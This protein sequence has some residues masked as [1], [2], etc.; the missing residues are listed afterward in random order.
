[1]LVIAKK[2]S[3][4]LQNRSVVF[5]TIW[6]SLSFFLFLIVLGIEFIKQR[7][8]LIPSKSTGTVTKKS[9]YRDP[10]I[11]IPFILIPT[12]CLSLFT[13][14]IPIVFSILCSMT[15]QLSI[16]SLSTLETRPEFLVILGYISIANTIFLRRCW[17]K[18]RRGPCSSTIYR[19]ILATV[20]RSLPMILTSTL[21][22][23]FIPLISILLLSQTLQSI[24]L[25]VSTLISN[26]CVQS[27]VLSV[28]LIRNT[29]NWCFPS[30]GTNFPLRQCQ[31]FIEEKL[32][33]IA[34]FIIKL[35][36]DL[37]SSRLKI[38]IFI[39]YMMAILS[40][41][42]VLFLR[43]YTHV[44]S[45][46]RHNK[47]QI[48]LEFHSYYP[49]ILSICLF[50]IP[51]A[52]LISINRLQ[53]HTIVTM[54]G[55]SFSMIVLDV[56]R[57]LLLYDRPLK[58]VEYILATVIPIDGCIRFSL[59][60]RLS[61]KKIHAAKV[62]DATDI[63]FSQ[64]T[65]SSI[66]SISSLM[67]IF[68]Y[69][70]SVKFIPILATVIASNWLNTVV[71]YPVATTLIGAFEFGKRRRNSQLSETRSFHTDRFSSHFLLENNADY[72]KKYNSTNYYGNAKQKRSYNVVITDSRRASMPVSVHK[73]S[74]T[75]PNDPILKKR[76][77]ANGAHFSM[78]TTLT[79]TAREALHLI[80]KQE[81]ITSD[82]ILAKELAL[83]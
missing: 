74:I 56:S 82:N 13:R 78:D 31:A 7:S 2:I 10:I 62:L 15:L 1:M 23:S 44:N 20:D 76:S 4:Q 70:N 17:E 65:L 6:T 51:L 14:S 33:Y 36:Q 34:H 12:V 60:Y 45:L 75:D 73:I 79:M 47:M 39:F 27:L 58:P 63:S 77:W 21:C 37:L 11:L 54:L 26:I 55:F 72:T 8:E 49:I 46:I 30:I 5:L 53:I 24:Y 32:V 71:F 41:L 52:V 3:K 22:A 38:P 69:M 29:Y 50:V 64:T 48:L 9:V 66:S 81:S 40:Y 35:C 28:L 83:Y 59:A 43:I 61:R 19:I 67:F 42:G 16:T 18:Y 25:S 80:R 68:I 57:E